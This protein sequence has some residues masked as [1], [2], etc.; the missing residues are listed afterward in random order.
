M[1]FG[2]AYF[3]TTDGP[4]TLIVR[5][6]DESVLLEIGR[7]GI[8]GEFQ[9]VGAVGLEAG[10]VQ[11]LLDALRHARRLLRQRQGY[12]RSGAVTVDARRRP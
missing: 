9:M 3:R 5:P 2:P 8:H 6:L 10:Q 1:T 7:E 4:D 11:Q 12:H